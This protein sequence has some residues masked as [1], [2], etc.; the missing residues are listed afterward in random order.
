MQWFIE[1]YMCEYTFVLI[2]KQYKWGGVCV[3][4]CVCVWVAQSYL[5]VCDPVDCSPPGSFCLWDSP[6]KSTGVDCHFFLQRNWIVDINY[7]INNVCILS[8]RMLNV[9]KKS[10]LIHMNMSFTAFCFDFLDW[11]LCFS[12]CYHR[13][14]TC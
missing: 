7:D 13:G 3:C 11:I 9:F 6:G 2:R 8:L 1:F 4:V 12:Y 5:T 10:I 14:L